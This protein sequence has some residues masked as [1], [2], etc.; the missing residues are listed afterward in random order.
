VYCIATSAAALPPPTLA[1]GARQTNR[2]LE[3]LSAVWRK[4]KLK[5]SYQKLRIMKHYELIF[6]I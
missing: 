6:D 5:Y 3:V 1:A 4:E 2:V